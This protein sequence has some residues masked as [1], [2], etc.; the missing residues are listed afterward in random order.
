MITN[1]QSSDG[2]LFGQ[3]RRRWPNNKP[4]QDDRLVDFSWEISVWLVDGVIYGEEACLRDTDQT[5]VITGCRDIHGSDPC[6]S[7]RRAKGGAGMDS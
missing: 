6:A 7:P 2:L 4:S 5:Y 1:R 3:R